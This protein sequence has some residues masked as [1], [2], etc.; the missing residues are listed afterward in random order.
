MLRCLKIIAKLIL[1]QDLSVFWEGIVQTAELNFCGS[2]LSLF[3]C[4]KTCIKKHRQ[5][6]D[7]TKDNNVDLCAV[8]IQWFSYEGLNQ[9]TC[10]AQINYSLDSNHHPTQV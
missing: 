10:T 4:C 3:S 6:P 2:E 1:L 9:K 8:K 5:I 7:H